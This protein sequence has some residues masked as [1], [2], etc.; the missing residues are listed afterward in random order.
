LLECVPNVSE[1]RDSAVL[2]AL[3]DA[4]RSHGATLADVHRDPDHH[5]SVFTFF[6]DAGDVQRAALALARMAIERIDVR[7]HRGVHPRIGSLDV[8]PFVPLRGSSMPDAVGVAHAV[9]RSLA[10]TFDLPVYFYGEA[11]L[12]A[13]RR[14]LP[15]VRGHGWETLADR[16]ADPSWTPDAGPARPHPS[17]GAAIVGARPVLIAFNAVLATDDVAI[18][19]AVAGAVRFSSGG[20]PAVRA[21]G[22]SLASRGHAQVAMNLLDYRVTPPHVVAERV[23]QEAKRAGTDVLEYELVGCAPADAFPG[24]LHR[25]I[26]GL[27][28][29]QLLDPALFATGV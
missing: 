3:A 16:L 10:E 14:E 19:R 18:A 23:E 5:R 22:V 25:P 9:G 28:P 20:L 17:A 24:P 29:S 12:V 21:I 27:R 2:D 7:R 11:A 15:A 8:M 4:V 1:G 26:A 6:G 13:G